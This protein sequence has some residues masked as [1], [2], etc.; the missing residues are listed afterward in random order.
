MAGV[1]VALLAPPVAKQ[2]E[3]G[4]LT[5]TLSILPVVAAAAALARLQFPVLGQLAAMHL[6]LLVVMALVEKIG[7]H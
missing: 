7:C 2:G 6:Q 4:T 1:L 3:V 5:V